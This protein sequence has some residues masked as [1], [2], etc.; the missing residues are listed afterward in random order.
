MD[1]QFNDIFILEEI[2]QLQDM[3]SDATGVASI[4]T[5]P[6]GTLITKPS[7]F[8]RL[9]N[10]IIRNTPKGCANCIKSDATIG[11]LN[12]CQV[13]V[14]HCLSAGLWDAGVPITVGGNHIANW[15]IG[16]VQ[17]EDVDLEKMKAYAD[18]IGVDR[19][20]FLSALEEVPKMTE[21]RFKKVAE[22]LHVFVIDLS[23]KAYNNLQLKNE[24]AKREEA[25]L[26]L[27][28]SQES[29]Y[30]TLHSIGDGVISTDR[31]GLIN[32]MNP[33]AEQ[34]CGWKLKD[35]KGKPLTQVFEI[36]NAQTRLPVENPVDKVL[37][38]GQIVGLA[39]HTVLISKD[40]TEYQIADSAAP[41]K[42]CEGEI[43]GIVLV[44]SDVTE[45][46]ESEESQKI[47]DKRYSDL[48]N[49]LEA[50]VVVHGPDT[51]IFSSN[52]RASELLGLTEM[53]MFGKMAM[54]PDWK[55]LAPNSSHLALEDYPVNLIA[56]TKKPIIDYVIGIN[57]P[58]TN[59]LVW[60][61]VNG[62]PMLNPTGEISEIIISFIDITQR[63]ITDEAL[64]K[65]REDFKELYDNAPIGYHE[66]DNEGRIIRINQTELKMLGYTENEVLGQYG[67]E[68]LEDKEL[69]QNRIQGKLDG[70]INHGD[71]VERQFLRKDGTKLIFLSND[72]I[73][74]DQNDIIIGIRTTVQDITKRKYAEEAL[75][76]EK[77]LLRT[78][79]DNM[80]DAIYTKDLESRKTLANKADVK[81]LGANLELEVLGK[82]DFDIFPK[83]MAEGFFDDDQSVLK[84]GEPIL[85]REEYLM[86]DNGEKR[87][88]L[89]S[90]LPLFNNNHQVIGLVGIGRDITIRR[91]AELALRKSESFLKETQMIAKVGSYSLD[92]KSGIW[93]SSEVLD[94]VFG[95]EA[96]Y[97]KTL[98]SWK[99]IIHPEWQEVMIDYFINEV[100]G[101]KTQ[102]N[103]EYK[104]IS[105]NDG[106]EKWVHG[107]GRLIFG[108]N[109]EIISM[110]GSIQD[111][112]ELKQ[113]AL[114]LEDQ[115]RMQQVLMN[116]SSEYINLPINKIEAAIHV[117][118]RNL[119]EYVEADRAY[120]FD[121]NLDSQN[122]NN[123]YEWCAEGIN[124][125]IAS[126]KAIPLNE[127]LG[128]EAHQKGELVV[129][130]NVSDLHDGKLKQWL[131]NRNLKS[132]ITIPMMLNGI[133]IGFVGFD[134]FKKQHSYTEHEKYLFRAFA[135]MLVNIQ[136]RKEVDETLQ[137]ERLLLR[138]VIDNIPDTIYAKDLNY[139]KTLANKAEV[140]ILGAKSEADVVGKT[141]SEFY[142]EEYARRFK[143]SDQIVIESG[144]PDF[145]REG[146]IVD[147]YGNNRWMLSSKLPL[148]NKDNQ[149]VGLV[150]IGH[151]ISNRILAEETLR[152]SEE[153]YR[154]IFENVQDVYFQMNLLGEIFEISP[155]IEKLYGYKREEIIGKSIYDFYYQN[156]DSINLSLL[157]EKRTI[158]D[159]EFI[160][161]NKKGETKSILLNAQLIFDAEGHPNHIDGTIRD[162]SKRKNAEDALKESERKFR[163]IL[164]NSPFHIWA[165][166]GE[167]Y[168]YVNKA[169]FDFTGIEKKDIM[170]IEMWTLCLHPDDLESAGKVW[171]D[172]WERKAEHDN[173]FRLLSK[174]GIY[175]D[176]WCH[177]VPIYD[178]FQ[179]FKHFQG[180]NFDITER[181]Q[182]D[183]ALNK[184]QDELQK[185]A[186]HLQNVREEERIMLAR[187]IHDELGQ[188]LIAIKI[189]TGL[190]K[191]KV[192]KVVDSINYSEILT[193]FENL[194]GLVDN[195]INTA[196]KIMTDLRPEVLY[197]LGFE[198]AVKL[199]I[200]KFQ[201]RH[202]I[203][204]Q[205]YTED[206]KLELT[207]QQSVALYRIV[208]EALTN[209]VKH[210]KATKVDIHI[211]LVDN[212]L[213][214]EIND[215]GV[216]FDQNFKIKSD[217]YG[218]IGMKE[219]VYLLAGELSIIGNAGK[220]TSLRVVMPY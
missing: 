106:V 73:L 220:G 218:L 17:A 163:N 145:N 164:E 23:E 161:K 102:F 211:S 60:V 120:V 127:M 16:Q 113:T 137:N 63:T 89:T 64:I 57:R 203:D 32:E 1:I 159:L 111:I 185:F 193:K 15:L 61:M 71:S 76:N 34:L 146:L 126:M 208:Q 82:T 41:I 72:K 190:L 169:Y 3:F 204:C 141:D 104:I 194:F 170:T 31:N 75:E 4:I 143:A 173:Y 69:S 166:D 112:T 202:N 209:I 167:V 56:R 207:E 115:L 67:W 18:E 86:D 68:F 122:S 98:E 121:Y 37:E 74:K 201:V 151:D 150:G 139:K 154:N 93:V 217:S 135:Q 7:N 101:K 13:V 171:N 205:F 90:K 179:Q 94:K 125:Q 162:I 180:F 148:R 30:I 105:I 134:S 2:Q 109:N 107:I 124:A 123:T 212:V 213:T 174:D 65:S 181:K 50:G 14:K 110:I 175:R 46:Y 138:T 153:K 156:D 81:N 39:N 199:H 20:E 195:T 87:W 36:V 29:L 59:D 136:L 78:L 96:N 132:F 95:I 116:I 45:K 210:A 131:H 25:N 44:F 172:A 27:Q 140:K 197:L 33:V 9:C 10:D 6:D 47:S 144:I 186:S 99:R 200:S 160:I 35:A 129:I 58:V 103:K 49:H 206:T 38:N 189:D 85:N 128:F 149:I 97:E 219:R 62:F 26:K 216:G 119:A 28:K 48:L 184:S 191:Q 114:A 51:A 130:P 182:A 84:K 168:N 22:M 43:T 11:G 53:Q 54:H 21:N 188:I 187:E 83:K 79:I 158:K 147:G 19:N 92:V 100:I 12:S 8:T 165:F 80:P 198:E 157:T 66:L 91:K 88:L 152:K 183:E 155:S 40:K 5:Q 133:T 55:F 192:L 70:T 176:F 52:P 42:N 118:L 117:S 196:R 108:D 177:V 178:E 77:H 142:D 215:N 24:I 214:L